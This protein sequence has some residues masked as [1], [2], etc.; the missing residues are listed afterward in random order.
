M[1]RST[2]VWAA[3]GAVLVG[4]THGAAVAQ[5]PPIPVGHLATN[6]GE[7]ASVAQ[8][9]AQ[10]VTDAL[11]YINSHGGVGGRRIA[12][13]TVDYGY[14]PSRAVSA[15]RDWQARL[16]P[17]AVL[18]WGTADTEALVDQVTHDQVVF[19]SGSASGHLTDPTGRSGRTSAAPY[20]FF[21]GPSYSDGCRGAVQWAA[22][23]WRRTGGA[24]SSAF[25]QDVNRPRFVYM[26]DNHPYPNA[27]LAACTD[28]ARD[29]GFEVLPPIRYSLAPGNFAA[30]CQALRESHAQY[31]FLGNTVESNVALVQACASTGVN[32]QFMTNMY[33]WDET[34]AQQAGASGNGMVWVV[35]AAPWDSPAPAMALVREVSR[36]S[37]SAGSVRRPVHYMRGVC[38]AFLLR[39]ALGSAGG[40]QGGITGANVRAALEQMNN[41]VPN[42]LE[43]VCQ[44]STWT[45]QDHRGSTRIVL[46]RSNVT[47]GQVAMSEVYSTNLPLRPDWLG[48]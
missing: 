8:V 22:E 14:D 41:H 29:L 2:F 26:G 16:H 36:V 20:N 39:D 45:A 38:T 13:E 1:I 17:V 12:L 48:W 7:T 9:Y 42:G 18:G 25:L 35:T 40:M 31:V 15:Y 27:P 30:H 4:G 28:Y 34:A 5:E 19:L 6:T 23:D 46:Y 44:P 10:G 47:G 43:G 21:Y 11:D 33:G 3:L 37:D 24:N 32:A